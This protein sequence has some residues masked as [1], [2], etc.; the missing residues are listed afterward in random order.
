V[1]LPLLLTHR[2][3]EKRANCSSQHVNESHDGD[4][5]KCDHDDARKCDGADLVVKKADLQDTAGSESAQAANSS[6]V[7][8][9][10]W[11]PTAP[12]D[13]SQQRQETTSTGVTDVHETAQL[14]SALPR[15][16]QPATLL[17]Q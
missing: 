17:L 8:E 5:H 11:Q 15:Q 9:R 4:S 12:E 7:S 10:V 16:Q 2:S 1:L 14:N 6:H 13:G 3:H